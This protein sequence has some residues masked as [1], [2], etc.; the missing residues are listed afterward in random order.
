MGW[1]RLAAGR[2]WP[3]SQD[4]D[5]PGLME[6]PPLPQRFT[7]QQWSNRFFKCAQTYALYNTSVYSH[8]TPAIPLQ[9]NGIDVITSYVWTGRPDAMRQTLV[10]LGE[11]V[12][13]ASGAL[14]AMLPGGSGPVSCTRVCITPDTFSRITGGMSIICCKMLPFTKYQTTG[15]PRSASSSLL[16]I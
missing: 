9:A 11:T 12:R 1:R 7:E 4:L 13:K 2:I 16:S 5:N 8:L 6:V 3:P 15:P 10:K 14:L